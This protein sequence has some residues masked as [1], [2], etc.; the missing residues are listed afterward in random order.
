MGLEAINA[1]FLMPAAASGASG[2]A[3]QSGLLRFA[4]GREAVG[5]IPGGRDLVRGRR[6]AEAASVGARVKAC[7]ARA[8]AARIVY[9]RIVHKY[10][11]AVVR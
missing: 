3:D 7:S 4:H 2:T 9:A 8:Q 10:L 5:G 1:G 6:L 11:G